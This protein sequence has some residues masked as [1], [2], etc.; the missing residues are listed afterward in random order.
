MKEQELRSYQQF[1]TFLEKFEKGDEE[2][3]KHS[4]GI[5][6]IDCIKLISNE[7][8]SCLKKKMDQLP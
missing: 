8:N 2:A 6:K 3:E 1:A 7:D 4:T 5:R